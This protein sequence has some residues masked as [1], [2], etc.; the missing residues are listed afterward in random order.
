MLRVKRMKLL[1]RIEESEVGN[2]KK[3]DA[4]DEKF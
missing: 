2:K 3:K 4:E 1:R